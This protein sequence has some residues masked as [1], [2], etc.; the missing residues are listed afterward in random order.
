MTEPQELRSIDE[1]F[2]NTFNNLPDTPADSGWDTPSDQVW[3]HVHEQIKAPGSGWSL[4]SLV[5]SSNVLWLLGTALSIT[6]LIGLY[7]AFVKPEE[8]TVKP[9]PPSP[10]A[11]TTMVETPAPVSESSIQT[12]D[13]KPE[14]SPTNAAVKQKAAHPSLKVS[15]PQNASAIEPV[16]SRDEAPRSSGATPLPGTKSSVKPNTR[17]ELKAERARQLELEWKKPVELL[18]VPRT[19]QA[20]H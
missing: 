18:P 6:V 19:K 16:N 8:T 14:V 20:P 9:I 11:A 5:T 17:E 12:T 1:L 2:R 13:I 15:I 3:K 10:P 4:K 7:Y